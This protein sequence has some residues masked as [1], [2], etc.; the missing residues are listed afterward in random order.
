MSTANQTA[1]EA[2]VGSLEQFARCLAAG[3]ANRVEGEIQSPTVEL[4]PATL[5]DVLADAAN[6]A[7][8]GRAVI[9][10]ESAT[11]TAG[12]LWTGGT[13]AFLGADTPSLGELSEED[14]QTLDQAL[15]ICCEEGEEPPP[16]EWS[17]LE[18]VTPE[19][20][21]ES[22]RQLGVPEQCE[23]IRIAVIAG[24]LELTFH[25]VVAAEEGAAATE[26]P[27]AANADPPPAS[28][29]PAP[30]RPVEGDLVA[31]AVA[32]AQDPIPDPLPGDLPDGLANLQHLLDVRI[33]LTIRLGTTRMTLEDILRIAKGTIVEL[34]QREEEPLEVLANGRV[35][36]RGEVVVVDDRFGLRIT[37]IGDAA[38]RLRAG[39]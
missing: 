9:G 33:P 8:L 19:G 27:P 11:V 2:A 28:P 5:A 31:E 14:A 3:L 23:R 22:L 10:P 17:A 6:G 36:A 35:I 12:L 30:S 20:V 39:R 34:Q 21:A 13:E 26:T 18:P 24:E 7:L 15:R 37:E 29:A 16:M 1:L 4:A 25:V 38:E 32:G